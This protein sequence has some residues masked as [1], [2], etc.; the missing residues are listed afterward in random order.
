MKKSQFLLAGLVLLSMS[1]FSSCDNK[2]TTANEKVKTTEVKAVKK[3]EKPKV[4][5]EEPKQIAKP[6]VRK[7]KVKQ[8]EWLYSISRREYGTSQG[9]IKIYEANKALIENPD[10]IFPNQELI[11]PE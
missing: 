9:W 6:M 7:V 4:I 10:L 2:N 11:I 5:K 8:D 1:I 3:V